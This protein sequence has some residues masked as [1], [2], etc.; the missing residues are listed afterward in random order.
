MIIQ[1]TFWPSKEVGLFAMPTDQR[2][3][4]LRRRNSQQA[5]QQFGQR[6]YWRIQDHTQA[7][8]LILRDCNEPFWVRLLWW[9]CNCCQCYNYISNINAN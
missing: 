4:N 7:N 1:I 2:R 8:Y 9:K 6:K 3:R 5:K